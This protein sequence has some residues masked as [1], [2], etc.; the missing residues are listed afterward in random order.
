MT[1]GEPNS[2]TVSALYDFSATDPGTFIFDP[3]SSFQVT[4]LNDTDEIISDPVVINAEKAG[5]ISITV[6]DHVS[7]RELGLEKRVAVDCTDLRKE[8]TI[9]LSFLDAKQLAS[10]ASSYIRSHGADKYYKKYFRDGFTERVIDNFDTIANQTWEKWTTSCSTTYCNFGDGVIYDLHGTIHY[11]DPFYT[12]PSLSSFCNDNDHYPR[13]ALNLRELSLLLKQTHKTVH[14]DCAYPLH[15][16]LDP[17][18]YSDTYSVSTQTPRSLPRAR[19]LTWDHG[20]AVL[21]CLHL[22]RD[23]V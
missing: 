19:A 8:W 22:Q 14:N 5:P 21:R 1:L 6:T 15:D 4:R 17:M 23:Q 20:F 10:E 9:F 3:V 13:G 2:F 12:L 16:A 11:C 7:K 18:D